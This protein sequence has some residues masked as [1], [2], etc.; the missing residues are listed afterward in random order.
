[1][2]RLKRGAIARIERCETEGL[3]V[4]CLRP[5]GKSRVIRGCHESCRKLTQ[6]RIE[7]GEW[8]EE[9]RIAEGKLL[10][11]KPGRRPSNP[12]TLE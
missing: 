10:P 12:V 1:M 5:L 2:V 7:K 11:P 4:A 6:D 3:C 9:G 8:T